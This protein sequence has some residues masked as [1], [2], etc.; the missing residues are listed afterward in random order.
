MRASRSRRGVVMVLAILAAAPTAGDIGSCGQEV[1]VLDRE[2][3][4]RAK[5]ATDCEKCVA[6]ALTTK[7]CTRACDKKLD[8]VPFPADCFPLV[9][10]GEVCLRK[11]EATSCDDYAS[12]VADQGSTIPTECNFCPLELAPG[13]GGSP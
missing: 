1:V 11:L 8:D 4:F 9:H 13:A 2:K 10:D 12:F 5:E 3:F 7:A 6:C